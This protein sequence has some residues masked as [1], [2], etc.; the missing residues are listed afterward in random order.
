[1][2][3]GWVGSV[4]GGQ[5]KE[6]TTSS[7]VSSRCSWRQLLR[8]KRCHFKRSRVRKREQGD[9]L[10]LRRTH[11]SQALVVQAP[12]YVAAP[13]IVYEA[14]GKEYVA[15]TSAARQH[16]TGG[17]DDAARGSPDGVLVDARRLRREGESQAGP[18][19]LPFDADSNEPSTLNERSSRSCDLKA[20]LS[21]CHTL[22]AAGAMARR[23]P[24]STPSSDAAVVRNFVTNGGGAMAGGFGGDHISES[25]RRSSRSPRTCRRPQAEALTPS[26]RAPSYTRHAKTDGEP[27]EPQGHLSGEGSVAW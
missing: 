8:G 24:I 14:G 22:A 20:K 9:A 21:T 16:L 19:A 27:D 10:S 11:R 26:R 23:V 5:L 17:H 13:P 7:G 6:Q 2:Y 12:E 3:E 18:G 15:T 4:G 1:V 25:L